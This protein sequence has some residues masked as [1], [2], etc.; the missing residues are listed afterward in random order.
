MLIFFESFLG[1]LLLDPLFFFHHLVSHVC[2]C[3]LNFQCIALE[4]E[5]QALFFQ[6]IERISDHRKAAAAYRVICVKQYLIQGFLRVN[7]SVVGQD[8]GHRTPLEVRKL[9]FP[10]VIPV[11]FGS[12]EKAVHWNP[13]CHL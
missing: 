4:P 6:T 9:V 8:P 1:I 2:P 7:L 10:H 3:I 12:M 11:K 5:T 13:P